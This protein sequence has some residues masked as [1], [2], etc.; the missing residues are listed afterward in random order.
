MALALGL[1]SSV[2]PSNV[3]V[4][5]NAP[6]INLYGRSPFA[7]G[8]YVCGA[9]WGVW[10]SAKDCLD[11]VD[12]L[13]TGSGLVI[14]TIDRGTG[15]YHLPQG[16]EHG[17]VLTIFTWE[18]RALILVGIGNCMIQVEMA[19]QRTPP[20][21]ELI[22]DHV[23]EVARTL[24]ETCNKETAYVGGFMFGNLHNLKGWL[25]SPEGEIDKPMRESDTHI[26]FNHYPRRHLPIVQIYLSLN[27]GSL[28]RA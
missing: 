9:F 7:G 5:N 1:A 18:A 27:Y 19:G 15:R 13:P 26:S 12:K 23:R 21:I 16:R 3:S 25:S 24:V 2:A 10:D 22:P 28:T 4:S 14:Y 6:V 8:E 11:A 17:T 20:T